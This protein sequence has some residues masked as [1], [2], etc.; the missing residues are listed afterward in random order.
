MFIPDGDLRG[1]EGYHIVA[2]R[3]VSAGRLQGDLPPDEANP[4]PHIHQAEE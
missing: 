2:F 4:P 1:K 3:S